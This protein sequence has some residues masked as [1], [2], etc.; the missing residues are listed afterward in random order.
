MKEVDI[1]KLVPNV[2]SFE[3]SEERYR[4]EQAFGYGPKHIISNQEMFRRDPKQPT[5]YLDNK[6]QWAWFG[7]CYKISNVRRQLL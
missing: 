3:E 5:M 1:D 7:W 2:S 6:I 4:F